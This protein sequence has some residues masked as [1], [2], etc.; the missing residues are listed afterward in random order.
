MV[1]MHLVWVFGNEYTELLP[2]LVLRLALLRHKF[3]LKGE[4]KIKS[5]PV[6]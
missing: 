5:S 1:K 2:Q 3:I 4:I 6:N